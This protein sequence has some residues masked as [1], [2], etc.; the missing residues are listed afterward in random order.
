[1][2]AEAAV[3]C[4]NKTAENRKWLSGKY[5]VICRRFSHAVTFAI[6]WTY[7]AVRRGPVE[8]KCPVENKC[9]V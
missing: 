6:V 3:A 8:S 5:F 1:M 4:L 7:L 9:P 2:T